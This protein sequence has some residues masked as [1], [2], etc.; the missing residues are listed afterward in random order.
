MT[1]TDYQKASIIVLEIKRKL[2]LD[3]DPVQ[4]LK[5][6]CKFLEKQ[7]DKTLKDIG[8]RMMNKAHAT[9]PIFL[10]PSLHNLTMSISQGSC[11]CYT[12]ISNIN[13]HN[14]SCLFV[15]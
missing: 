2:D 7:E 10:P 12:N 1:G 13:Y 8:N 5:D 14:I 4:Y 15:S 11:K 9:V 6:I 3:D